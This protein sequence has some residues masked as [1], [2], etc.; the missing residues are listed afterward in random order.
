[1]EQIFC[2]LIDKK[3]TVLHFSHDDLRFSCL[4]ITWQFSITLNK[5]TNAYSWIVSFFLFTYFF[6]QT[7]R[8]KPVAYDLVKWVSQI[9]QLLR[10]WHVL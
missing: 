8:N 1:M 5:A 3:H 2:I 10:E 9:L 7:G 4:F 6:G